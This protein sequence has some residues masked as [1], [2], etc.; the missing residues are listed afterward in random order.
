MKFLRVSWILFLTLSL[1]GCI[2]VDSSDQ[3][4]EVRKQE[5]KKLKYVSL[6]CLFYATDHNNNLPNNFREIKKYLPPN[7]DLSF[8]KLLLN[9]R[10]IR[11]I[12]NPSEAILVISQNPKQ[13]QKWAVVFLD[14]HTSL[15]DQKLLQ[16]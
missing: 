5:I 7:F 14:G 11:E 13:G 12:D 8:L 16:L 10:N 6:A 15:K 2:W 9:N 4:V 3:N 1:Y